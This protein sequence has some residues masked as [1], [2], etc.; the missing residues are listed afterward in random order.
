[1]QWYLGEA[2]E[3]IAGLESSVSETQYQVEQREA[4]IAELQTSLAEANHLAAKWMSRWDSLIEE[5][6]KAGG[7]ISAEDISSGAIIDKTLAKMR[8]QIEV[9]KEQQ[10]ELENQLRAIQK[11]RDDLLCVNVHLQDEL[12][13][14]KEKYDQLQ[15]KYDEANWYLG[16]ARHKLDQLQIS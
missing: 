16:E 7:E 11:D 14:H 9:Y 12:S 1:L 4:Y 5:T 6:I 13:D 8:G 3:A 10:K 15:S 2:R